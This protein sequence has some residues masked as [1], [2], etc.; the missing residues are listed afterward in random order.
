METTAHADEN[1]QP[2]QG[3]SKINALAS[4]SRTGF[5]PMVEPQ[6]VQK[7][8][9]KIVGY[10]AAFIH[11]LS[12]DANAAEVI[13]PLW[14][15]LFEDKSRLPSDASD[16]LYGVIYGKPKEKRS[17]PDELQYI[18][19]AAVREAGDLPEGMVYYVVPAHTFAMV[20][21]RGPIQNI[22]ETCHAIYRQWL[23]DSEW[24]HAGIADV[25]RYDERFDGCSENS[26]ME[27]GITVKPKESA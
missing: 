1:C 5:P 24:E 15:R 7:P 14:D 10:E 8:E 16:E 13:P 19:G 25:E 3:S 20:T 9:L 17:H 2:Q 11:V 23:P 12:P 18:A 27:Y 26:E 4:F 22:G 6:I 21:H